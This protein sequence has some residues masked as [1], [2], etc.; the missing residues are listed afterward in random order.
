M[1]NPIYAQSIITPMIQLSINVSFNG[2]VGLLS[3]IT[4]NTNP[5]IAPTQ[6]P[7]IKFIKY[8]C[9]RMRLT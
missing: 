5:N 3:K 4:H 1:I 7:I 9:Y 2:V 8:D 6:N